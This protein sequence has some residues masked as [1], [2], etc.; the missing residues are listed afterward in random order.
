[1]F[2]IRELT[3]IRRVSIGEAPQTTETKRFLRWSDQKICC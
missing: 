1:M 3:N 2:R